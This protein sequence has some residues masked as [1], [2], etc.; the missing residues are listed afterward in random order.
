MEDSAMLRPTAARFEGSARAPAAH[1]AI[2]GHPERGLSKL[3]NQ[4]FSKQTT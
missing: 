4:S 1:H 3:S 2:D